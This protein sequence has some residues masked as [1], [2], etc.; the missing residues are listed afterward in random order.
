MGA[1]RESPATNRSHQNRAIGPTLVRFRRHL[2]H[3]QQGGAVYFVTFRSVRGTLTDAAKRA[4]CDCIRY[5][6]GKTYS[7]YAAVVMPDHAHILLQPLEKRANTYHDLA[8]IMRAVKG[9]SARMVNR[10]HGTTG[11]L[12][13]H[14]SYDRIIRSEEDFLEKWRYIVQNPVKAGIVSDGQDYPFLIVPEIP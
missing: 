7:L 4:V 8:G 1:D 6:H 10:L 11:Q 2:P 5:G 12:W 9:I 3:W 14:E 13:D